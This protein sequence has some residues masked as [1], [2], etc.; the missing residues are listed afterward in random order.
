MVRFVVAKLWNVE[1][2]NAGDLFAADR[3]FGG[4]SRGEIAFLCD[5]DGARRERRRYSPLPWVYW[6]SEHYSFGRC[7]RE[8]S[9]YPRWLPL[10]VNSDH[11]L[12]VYQS[13][14]NL[15]ASSGAAV[16]LCWS[17]WRV[18]HWNNEKEFH[19]T[20][21]PWV[22]FRRLRGLAP[23]LSAQGTLVFLPHTTASPNE[24]HDDG[25]AELIEEA[26]SLPADFQPVVFCIQIHDVLKERHTPLLSAGHKLITF[27]DSTSPFFVERFYSGIN[28]FKFSASNAVGSH[29]FICEEAGVDFFLLGAPPQDNH[30]VFA[31]NRG[32]TMRTFYRRLEF[33]FKTRNQYFYKMFSDFPP[34]KSMKKER[35]IR[36]ALGLDLTTREAGKSLRALFWRHLLTNAAKIVWIYAKRWSANRTRLP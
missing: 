5:P 4:F 14:G 22:A 28:H 10:A 36:E 33:E 25:W 8:V 21:H 27:G 34:E 6:G 29:S 16:H 17:T 12:S 1:D 19:R 23:K 35:L 13:L 20:L 15:D 2:T 18:G 11:G 32:Q 7:Y 26:E 3:V 31:R 30:A 24:Y 9:G